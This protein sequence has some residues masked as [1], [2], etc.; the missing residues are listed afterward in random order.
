MV[1]VR[2]EFQNR[3]AWI[4]ETGS[5]GRYLGRTTLRWAGVERLRLATGRLIEVHPS[6]GEDA[7]ILAIV[8]SYRRRLGS[9]LE[10]VVFR[11]PAR[12]EMTDRR[13]GDHP[14]GNF[15]TDV[16]RE[17]TRA[18]LGIMN[19]GGIR[20]PLPAGADSGGGAM[21]VTPE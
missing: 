10:R 21:C 19:A 5:W 14:L 8:T 7:R 2:S 20:A 3:P 18:D 17:R 12:V 15:V 6:D 4:V 9:G 1:I 11:T 16:L 13:E